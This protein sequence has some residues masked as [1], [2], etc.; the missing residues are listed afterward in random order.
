MFFAIIVLQWSDW[1]SS[2]RGEVDRREYRYV[3]SFTHYYIYITYYY[4][5]QK[6]YGIH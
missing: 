4:L 6:D 5:K 2:S 1:V 3:Y